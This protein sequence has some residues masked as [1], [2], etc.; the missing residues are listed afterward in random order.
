MF[1]SIRWPVIIAFMVILALFAAMIT[2][3]LTAGISVSQ[4]Q[5]ILVIFV[6]ALVLVI[7]LLMLWISRHIIKPVKKIADMMP[8]IGDT[9]VQQDFKIKSN[10]EIGK[11]AASYN[12]MATLMNSRLTYLNDRF[13][14]LE[15]VIEEMNDG[16][17]IVDKNKL[18]SMMNKAA[19]KILNTPEGKGIGDP[20][21]EASIDYEIDALITLCIET[22]KYQ[23]KFI[24]TSHHKHV[25]GAAVTPLSE[26]EIFLV[27]LQDITELRQLQ[28]MRRDFI[29]NISHELRTPVSSIK[30]LAETLQD[31]ALN[32][33]KVAS[34][35]VNKIVVEADKMA[36]MVSELGNLSLL[37]SGRA[38]INKNSVS[39]SEI[40]S[41]AVNRMALPAERANLTLSI[42]DHTG[43]VLL[44][45][46]KI[47]LEQVLINLINNAIKFTGPGGSITVSAEKDNDT[48]KF[49]VKDTGIGI[50]PDELSRI[51]ERFYKVDKSHSGGGTGLGLAIARQIV[52][53]HQG[54]IW[55]ESI[56]GKGS[57]FYFSVPLNQ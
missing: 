42:Y 37:E 25:L 50:L 10:D 40:I 45:A 56:P 38:S 9:A 55:A 33:K 21:I 49:S 8:S 14:N 28:T 48:V 44:N 41:D 34:D 11:L 12:R 54:K 30:A 27:L 17:I 23:V 51:F 53:A 18:I 3:I 52:E 15:K 13:R 2:I 39:V 5:L 31:G 26:R 4:I 36:Q 32:D 16:I 19:G 57:A 47:R 6:L 7:I 43:G 22:G 46:D 29:T 1:N 24:E 35:F 20:F